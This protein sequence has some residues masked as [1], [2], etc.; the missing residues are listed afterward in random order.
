[1]SRLAILE[2]IKKPIRTEPGCHLYCTARRLGLLSHFDIAKLFNY[3]A[4]F[5]ILIFNWL[6][7]KWALKQVFFSDFLLYHYSDFWSLLHYG[8]F[9]KSGGKNKNKLRSIYPK[10]NES[11][12]NSKPRAQFKWFLYVFR[13]ITN[14]RSQHIICWWKLVNT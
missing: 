11:F 4:L 12:K 3:H 8:K 14:A 7:W 9:L 13:L 10:N 5:R 1:M 6:C 2:I